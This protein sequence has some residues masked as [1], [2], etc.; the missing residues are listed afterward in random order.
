VRRSIRSS[1]AES[2]DRNNALQES[3]EDLRDEIKEIN[4]RIDRQNTSE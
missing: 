3:I 2:L 4:D 1:H